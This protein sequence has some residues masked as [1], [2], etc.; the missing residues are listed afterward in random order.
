MRKKVVVTTTLNEISALL[1]ALDNSLADPDFRK[2]YM[3]YQERRAADRLAAK[4]RK[5]LYRT[6]TE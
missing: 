6:E 1:L 5:L 3:S 4:L 2:S